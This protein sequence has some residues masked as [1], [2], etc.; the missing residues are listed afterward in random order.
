[1]SHERDVGSGN[2]AGT[3]LGATRHEI[4]T[5]VRCRTHIFLPTELIKW[6][7]VP[8]CKVVLKEKEEKACLAVAVT[9][10]VE[11][12]ASV[13]AA[14][15]GN[16]SVISF[17]ESLCKMYPDLS[18]T[19]SISSTET[20]VMG[21]APMK[22]QFEGAEMGVSAENGGCKCGSNCTCDPCTCK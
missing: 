18:Y 17:H 21:V 10:A 8:S 13:A 22:A 19:E 1:M 7:V 12:T 6:S 11:A 4:R 9:A 20:L 5:R 2:R 3:T 14:A 15:E 16:D